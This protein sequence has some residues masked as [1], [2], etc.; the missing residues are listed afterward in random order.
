MRKSTVGLKAFFL[1][2]HIFEGSC[3]E[4][5]EWSANC[6][7]YEFHLNSYG[8]GDGQWYISFDIIHPD[9]EEQIS[10]QI[11]KAHIW[12]NFTRQK[13]RDYRA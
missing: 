5:L 8:L 13:W 1:Y 9:G 3:V 11:T 7:L 12:M 10:K 2:K 6:W 4:V